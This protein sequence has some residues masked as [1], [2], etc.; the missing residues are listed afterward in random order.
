MSDIPLN[1]SDYRAIARAL[2]VNND[3]IIDRTEARISDSTR[4]FSMGTVDGVANA[5]SRGDVY[6]SKMSEEGA[7]RVA[8]YFSDRN[9]NVGMSP[10]NWTSDNWISK[11]DLPMGHYIRNEIDDN[12]DGKIS[13]RE[14]SDALLDRDITI[15]DKYGYYD[16][17]NNK[18]NY[19][20]DSKPSYNHDYDNKPNYDYDNKPNYNNDYDNKPSS[21]YGN[22]QQSNPFDSKPSSS[23]GNSQQSNPFDSKPS[24]S[25]GNSQQSNP[26]DSKPSSSH[27][28]SQQSN[29]FGSSSKPSSSQ[30]SNPFN[31]K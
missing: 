13:R 27:G 21:S 25:Y 6:V 3:N 15:G 9:N 23:Y 28:N 26:F 29:P 16:D 2:D 7:D 20:Y 31:K 18:P 14:F 12:Y 8:E 17:Y 10:R 24:S 30:N 22:S 19:D 4:D 11:N 1:N 5:L